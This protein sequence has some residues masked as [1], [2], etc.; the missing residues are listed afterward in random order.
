MKATNGKCRLHLGEMFLASTNVIKKVPVILVNSRSSQ[1]DKL[2]L[3]T[4][5]GMLLREPYSSGSQAN[6]AINLTMQH[7]GDSSQVSTPGSAHPQGS[8][9]TPLPNLFPCQCKAPGSLGLVTTCSWVPV[10]KPS[11]PGPVSIVDTDDT[12]LVAT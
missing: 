5:S 11:V 9:R 1:D 8:A 7:P 4:H 3:H 12:I 2:S 6:R 10:A